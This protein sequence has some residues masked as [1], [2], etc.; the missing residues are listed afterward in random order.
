MSTFGTWWMVLM[1]QYLSSFDRA[2]GVHKAKKVGNH[3]NT[4]L[5]VAK[6]FVGL[7]THAGIIHFIFKDK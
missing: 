7:S 1:K 2:V 6:Q 5:S 4:K 3:Q